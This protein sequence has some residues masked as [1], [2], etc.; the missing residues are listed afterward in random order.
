MTVVVEQEDFV[1]SVAH[2]RPSVSAAELA[3]Y[4]T[5]GAAFNDVYDA[6]VSA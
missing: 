5:L 3:H 4:E 1:Q 6:D 2:V